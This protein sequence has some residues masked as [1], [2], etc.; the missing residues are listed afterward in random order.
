[1]KS[2]PM[3]MNVCS[4]PLL[5]IILKTSKITLKI[6]YKASNIK[7]DEVEKTS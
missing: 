6:V 4:S 3:P 5:M 1:M 2:I 7:T